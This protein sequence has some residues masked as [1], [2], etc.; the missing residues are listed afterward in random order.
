[1]V[2]A[3]VVIVFAEIVALFKTNGLSGDRVLA[4]KFSNSDENEVIINLASKYSFNTEIEA[5]FAR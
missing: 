1:M 4:E 5:I 3:F 2:I